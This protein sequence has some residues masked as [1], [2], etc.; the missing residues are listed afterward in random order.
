MQRGDRVG[1]YE[2]LDLLD[3]GGMAQVYRA[4]DTSL[5]RE[6]ALK[7]PL[8]HLVETE[9]YRH[10]FLRE[11]RAASCL[12]HP[13]IVKVYEVFEEDGVPWIAMQLVRGG[14]L[15]NRLKEGPVPTDQLLSW[16][17]QLAD[18]LDHAHGQGILHRDVNPN[19]ALL[20][21]AGRILLSDFGLARF[22]VPPRRTSDETTEVVTTKGRVLGTPTFMSPEQALG[23]DLD[24]RSDIFS[25]GCVLYAMCTGHSP[26]GSGEMGPLIDA[27]VH[28]EP[29]PISRFNYEVP[30]LIEHVVRK[31]LTKDPDRRYQSTRD[32]LVDLRN[33]RDGEGSGSWISSDTPP[34]PPADRRLR[35]VLA[36]LTLVLA[37]VVAW[38]LRPRG[39]AG[40]PAHPIQVTSAPGWEGSPAV[41]PDG[42]RVAYVADAAGN[43]DLYVT[44]A[45]GGSPLQLTDNPGPDHSPAWYPDGSALAFASRRGNIFGVW[46][47]GQM[48][49]DATLLVPGATDPALSPD[50]RWLAVALPD[51]NREWRIAVAPVDLPDAIRVLTDARHGLWGHHS[52]TWAADSRRIAFGSQ[53]EIQWITRD[54]TDWGSFTDD[55]EINQDP[56]WSS[57]DVLYFSSYREGTLALWKLSPGGDPIRLTFGS[58]PEQEPSISPDGSRLAYSTSSENFDLRVRNLAT[59]TETAIPGSRDDWMPSLARDGSAVAFISDR[60]GE[61]LDL[62]IQPLVAG[63]PD[64]EPQRVTSHPGDASHPSF[65]PDGEWIVYY[66][67]VDGRRDL[68]RVRVA[69]G[70]PERLTDHASPDIQPDWSPDGRHIVFSSERTGGPELW[71]LDVDTRA[72][73]PVPIPGVSAFAPRWVDSEHVVFVGRDGDGDEVWWVEVDSPATARRVTRGARA[74]RVAPA[75]SASLLVSGWWDN[76]HTTL[77]RVALASGRGTE[78]DP[79]VRFGERTA[80]ATFDLSAD[81]SVLVYSPQDLRG[82]VWILH[83][84]P[85]TY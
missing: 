74:L 27:I 44:D 73:R 55:G 22:L 32:L 8:P 13:S 17:E 2:V 31:C 80:L 69:G 78:L 85:G 45:H 29:D 76:D 35:W 60:H 46:R 37:A 14:P 57:R 9:A 54:G 68:W 83:A 52:P 12:D 51:S 1:R 3:Q 81:G 49:G 28:R 65:S 20:D 72:L 61:T 21:D 48:G 70:R 38:Q 71:V 43:L 47:I 64:G 41:S 36:V 58:G 84:S 59:G 24:E 10:R 63:E 67:I 18:A 42:S 82:D 39:E 77:R 53:D 66:R 19:N 34:P 7:R 15:R 62:W 26:F 75:D 40:S 56:V 50:G 4:M 79:P 30:P 11:A 25:F 33:A 5:H 6:V 16:S 23:R